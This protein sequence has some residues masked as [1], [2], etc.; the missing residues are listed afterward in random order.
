MS[1]CAI[2]N[3]TF[4]FA[5][6]TTDKNLEILYWEFLPTLHPGSLLT[7]SMMISDIRQ[8]IVKAGTWRV[9]VCVCMF[10]CM[11]AQLHLTL[12]NSMDC[13]PPCSSI[14]DG[15]LVAKSCPT[16]VTPCTVACQAP[17]SMGFSSQEHWSG[18]HFLLQGIFPTQE[19]N[20]GVLHWRQILYWLNYKGSPMGCNTIHS[21]KNLIQM[22]WVLSWVL[23][24]RACVLSCFSH[25]W[26][27]A[28]L[29]T[30][31]LQAPLSMRIL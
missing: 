2:S 12:C 16:L 26:L 10:A 25:V 6:V 22:S 28:T 11:H 3:I 27:F 13:S 31:A 1:L 29:W 15:G 9:C 4:Y 8:Y 24:T 21:G 7:T 17:L 19:S 14:R 5:I 18:F 30:V 23:Y 20:L